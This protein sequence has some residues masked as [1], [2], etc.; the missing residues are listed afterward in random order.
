M[1]TLLT[2]KERDDVRR[3][4]TKRRKDKPFPFFTEKDS[5]NERSAELRQTTPVH[6]RVL[7]AGRTPPLNNSGA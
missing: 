5:D 4:E 7:R 1:N 6:T 3:N 2:H